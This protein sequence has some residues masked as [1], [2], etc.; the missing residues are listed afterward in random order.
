VLL[1]L[2]FLSG[3]SGLVYQVVWVRMLTHVFGTSATAVGVVLAAFMSGL[4]LGSWLLGRAV[5]RHP[6][7]LT[8]AASTG[9]PSEVRNRAAP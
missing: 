4:S 6:N 9:G 3:V 2:F 5:D 8:N 1:V 7:P